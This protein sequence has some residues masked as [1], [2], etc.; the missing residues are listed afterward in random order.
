M[1]VAN[2]VVGFVPAL[3]LDRARK[4][5]EGTLGLRIYDG[6]PFALHVA[7]G[8]VPVRIAR[9]ESL[10]PQPFT[11]LG[12]NVRSISREIDGLVKRGVKFERFAT[13]PQDA[14]GVWT[15]P[16]GAKVAWFRDSEGNLLSITEAV[17]PARKLRARG[18]M[19]KGPAKRPGVKR[20]APKRPGAKKRPLKKPA[21]R[22]R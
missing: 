4:F 3:D 2:Q 17:P 9:V 22:R 8:G 11:I 10:Q 1:L 6:D 16:G 12:W 20:P 5:Y 7:A 19:A 14:R 15:A 21:R 18:I 13:M